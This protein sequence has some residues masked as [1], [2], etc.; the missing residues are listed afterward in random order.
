MDIQFNHMHEITDAWKG[1]K[2]LREGLGSN[3]PQSQSPPNA[4]ATTTQNLVLHY[5]TFALDCK[6]KDLSKFWHENLA[7]FE[8]RTSVW[9]PP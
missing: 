5:S 8:H 4:A 7:P 3:V 1:V 9:N 6:S 2:R